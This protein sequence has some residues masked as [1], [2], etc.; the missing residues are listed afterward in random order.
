M[1]LEAIS[2]IGF[3]MMTWMATCKI[4]DVPSNILVKSGMSLDIR[5]DIPHFMSERDTFHSNEREGEDTKKEK[6]YSL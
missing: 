3:G 2:W 1:D 4:N 5:A 6:I